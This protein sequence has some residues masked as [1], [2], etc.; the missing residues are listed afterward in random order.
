M[1]P[2][3]GR[4]GV[5]DDDASRRAFVRDLARAVLRRADRGVI[6][7][8]ASELALDRG[9]DRGIAQEREAVDYLVNR[10]ALIS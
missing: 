7:D 8:P 6:F 1:G 5:R 2:A 10:S 3:P 4:L 9:T